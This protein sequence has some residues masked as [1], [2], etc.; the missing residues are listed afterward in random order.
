L[1]R[2][3]RL[4]I[5]FFAQGEQRAAKLWLVDLAG[6]ERLSRSEATGDRMKEAQHINKSLS[7]LGD[8]IQALCARQDHV[9]YRNSKLTQVLQD[10]LG[11]EAKTL[12]YVQVRV[13]SMPNDDFSSECRHWARKGSGL[14]C[15]GELMKET[16][17]L[18]EKCAAL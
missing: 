6:S 17:K 5:Y 18:A 8:C 10:S 9:P 1:R 2:D 7:A 12:M 11:G 15:W 14:D 4:R 16:K 13:Y 3:E